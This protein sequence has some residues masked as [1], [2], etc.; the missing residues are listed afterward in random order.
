MVLLRGKCCKGIM[1]VRGSLSGHA[2]EGEGEPLAG[3]E[4]TLVSTMGWAGRAFGETVLGAERG[5]VRTGTR[6]ARR[7]ATHLLWAT[8]LF[9]WAHLPSSPPQPRRSSPRFRCARH[10][11]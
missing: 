1:R 11:R 5:K 9:E 3:T 8:I 10:A 6:T 2:M 4:A 7:K